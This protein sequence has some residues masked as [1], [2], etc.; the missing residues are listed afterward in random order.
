MGW[1]RILYFGTALL[2]YAF[3][4]HSFIVL[5][6][7]MFLCCH[8][9]AMPF[10]VLCLCPGG[11]GSSR[12]ISQW[13]MRFTLLQ[14]AAPA[15]LARPIR[16]KSG[17]HTTTHTHIHSWTVH[18]CNWRRSCPRSSIPQLASL[19]IIIIMVCID[20]VRLKMGLLLLFGRVNRFAFG[21]LSSSQPGG[22]A[23]RTAGQDDQLDRNITMGLL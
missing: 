8:S 14:A 19:I 15:A 12:A 23:G 3:T 5:A 21:Y 10:S 13:L 18:C 1:S 20:L 4:M 22:H 16:H 11:G 7:V 17:D 2:E 9:A 6:F